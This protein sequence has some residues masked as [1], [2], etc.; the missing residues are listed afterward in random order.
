MINHLLALWW[1]LLTGAV[2]WVQ[3]RIR[4]SRSHQEVVSLGGVT[5]NTE[6]EEKGRL[7]A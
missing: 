2:G 5:T 7:V 6:Q 1:E 4:D 3:S